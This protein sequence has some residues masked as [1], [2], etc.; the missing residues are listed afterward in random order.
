M[1][2]HFAKNGKEKK[3]ELGII[4][5][6]IE[7]GDHLIRWTHVALWPV[8]IHA[9]CLATKEESV[10]LI[11]F[12][13][14][15]SSRKKQEELNVEENE[16]VV[17]DDDNLMDAE[18]NIIKK[19]EHKENNDNEQDNFRMMLDPE[20]IALNNAIEDNRKEIKGAQRIEIRVIT[21][22]KE[23]QKWRKVEYGKKLG[24]KFWNFFQ[25]ND[26]NASVDNDDNKDEQGR[27]DETVN[28]DTTDG[29]NISSNRKKQAWW[30]RKDKVTVDKKNAQQTKQEISE[31]E[32]DDD[33]RKKILQLLLGDEKEEVA[34]DHNQ[35][36]NNNNEAKVASINEGND[37]VDSDVHGHDQDDKIII[38][39][40]DPATIVLARVR[41]L[42]NNPQILPPHNVFNSNSECIAVWC[43]T[44]RWSTIQAAIFLHA[45]AASN[46]KSAV[47]LSAL[48]ATATATTTTTMTAPAWGPLGWMGL[49]TTTTSTATVGWLSLHPWVVPLLAGYGVVAVGAPIVLLMQA[50]KRWEKTTQL[51]TDG[52]WGCAESDIYI[53]AIQSWSNIR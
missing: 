20:D 27:I 40:S 29:Q 2:S 50:R 43:K 7:K 1:L 31:A 10:T 47:S 51:L 12:G 49:T 42:L 33:D 23:L 41:Y 11:D 34:D 18:D 39:P 6:D 28:T 22:K 17:D 52:F 21:E 25:N 24:K 16:I 15:S 32:N 19:K 48:A 4:D 14:T 45:T 44:G 5:H 36:N 53:E 35:T 30:K 3:E 26:N 13:L 38:P 46:F 37:G 9:I 8:Q